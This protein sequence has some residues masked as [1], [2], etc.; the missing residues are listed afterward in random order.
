MG[1]GAVLGGGEAEG[2]EGAGVFG[3]AEKAQAGRLEVKAAE[4]RGFIRRKSS[5]RSARS[6]APMPSRPQT[7]LI[8]PAEARSS[9]GRCRWRPPPSQC[10]APAE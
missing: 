8:A 7:R 5:C 4:T 9:A 3:L 2:G 6:S 1:R 10:A